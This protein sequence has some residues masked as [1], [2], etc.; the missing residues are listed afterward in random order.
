MQNIKPPFSK[1]PTTFQEQIALLKS[2]GMLFNDINRAAHYLSH[3]NY[4]RLSA[5]WL[6]FEQTHSPSCFKQGTEFNTILEHY[7]FD[8]ELRLLLMDAVER[9]E[10]SL[11]T[12]WAYYL[13]HNYGVYAHLDEK[14]YNSQNGK[15]DYIENF[16]ILSK[17]VKESKEIFIRHFDQYKEVLPPIWVVCEIMTLGQLSK[18]YKNLKFR[19]DRNSIAKI[20]ELDE[21]ILS[22]F[23]HHLSI[24]RNI[25]AH[26]GRIWNREFTFTY[27]LPKNP[28][29]L[30]ANFNQIEKKRIYN[31]LVMLAY[32]MDKINPNKWKLKINDL[33]IRHPEI[34]RQ[35]MGFPENWK[36]L[37]MWYEVK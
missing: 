26:H 4:Y 11:R 19:K 37:S 30:F 33:F 32:L 20:Y 17:T 24:I 1:P 31:T 34:N 36:E 27:I 15:W 16:N 3:I 14:I 35:N 18:W 29:M 21:K 13:S 6:P 2:R 7:I 9:I 28:S 5:Y 12:Q 25:C 8:R 22:S 10:I 23:L